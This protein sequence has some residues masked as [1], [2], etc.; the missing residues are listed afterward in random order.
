VPSSLHTWKPA[1]FEGPVQP[2]DKPGSQTG[3]VFGAT[4]VL[5]QAHPRLMPI[6]AKIRPN[7]LSPL[8]APG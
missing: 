3:S 8:I 5:E 7:A 1:Q 4:V 6:A 2:S